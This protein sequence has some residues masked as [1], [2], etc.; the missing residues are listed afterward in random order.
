MLIRYPSHH[1]FSYFYC[2]L[3]IAYACIYGYIN[4]II[5]TCQAL[6]QRE[7]LIFCHYL[8]NSW[9]GGV[10]VFSVAPTKCIG[11]IKSW[12]N[13]G[14]IFFLTCQFFCNCGRSF[15]GNHC[16]RVEDF[17]FLWQRQ[18]IRR[19]FQQ[20]LLGCSM[21]WHTCI[22]LVARGPNVGREA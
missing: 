2:L 16:L 7:S 12:S 17:F 10:D 3:C 8:L 22:K 13:F 9:D 15:A 18:S 6:V 14:F 20:A 1:Y 19:C 11:L 5:G 4:S 21:L